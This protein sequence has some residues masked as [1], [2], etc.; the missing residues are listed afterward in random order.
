VDQEQARLLKQG[1]SYLAADFR[2]DAV[3][4]AAQTPEMQAEPRHP[5]AFLGV[6]MTAASIWCALQGF[7]DTDVDRLWPHLPPPTPEFADMANRPAV[8]ALA[9]AMRKGSQEE[10]TAA[11]AAMDT[12]IF[13]ASAYDLAHA[14][15]RVLA[16]STGKSP[17]E[18]CHIMMATVDRGEGVDPAD[19][20]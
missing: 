16:Q 15:L 11:G 14:T 7:P 17:A 6:A 2:Q 10:R 8:T 3:G 9:T 13:R 4:M 19:A 5:E 20:E 18:W 1:A 12:G